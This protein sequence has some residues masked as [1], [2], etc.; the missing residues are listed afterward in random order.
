MKK[1]LTCEDLVE[2]QR[3]WDR[4]SP[5]Q[6][7]LWHVLAGVGVIAGLTGLGWLLVWAGYQLER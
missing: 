7:R 6:V 1:L 3:Q 5:G 2:R 4:T